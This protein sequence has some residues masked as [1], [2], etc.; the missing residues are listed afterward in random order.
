M[1]RPVRQL[2]RPVPLVL[3]V[4]W[5]LRPTSD[6]PLDARQER[7]LSAALAEALTTRGL[8]VRAEDVFWLDEKAS[9]LTA[10]LARPRAVLLGRRDASPN[11]VYLARTRLSPEGRL[12]DVT[13]LYPIT[14]TSAVDERQLAVDRLRA[15]W[16]V[17]TDAT[18]YS[19]HLA[20]FRGS[21]RPGG[22][23]WTALARLQQRI[24]NWQE[25]GQPEGVTRRSFRLDPVARSLVLGF[26]ETALLIQ[27]D[28]RRIEV[29]TDG[30]GPIRG[31]RFVR[32]TPDH[33]AR[34]GNLVTWAV[35][36]AR[37]LP[38]FGNDRMQ[39]IKAVTFWA[40]DKLESAYGSVT[41]DDGSER[42]AEELG[43]LLES[44][45]PAYPNPETGWPPRP[46]EPMLRPALKGEGQ[47]VVLERDPFVRGNPGA[48]SPFALSFIRTDRAR[49]YSQIYVTI[50]DP[51]QVQLHAM[52]GTKEPKS[53]T[54]ETGPG[55]VPREPRVMERLVGAF[56]G[57]FQATHGEYGMVAER[58]VYL[59]PLP[60]AATVAET[61]EGWNLFG[62]WPRDTAVPD[63]I[64]SLRQNMTPLLMDGRVNPYRREW[65]GGVPEGWTDDSRTVRS[66]L[67]LTEENFVAYFYGPSID[68]NHL[69]SGMQR[70]RCQYGIHLDMNAGHTGLEFYHV[71]KTGALPG[72]D[73]PLDAQWEATG[74]V[75]GMPGYS[76]LGRRMI[77]FMALMNFPRYIRRDARDFFYLTLRSLLP[78]EDVPTALASKE[79]G[80]GAW[81]VQGLPQHGWPHA[82]ATT[83]VR[84]DATRPETKINLIKLDPKQLRLVSSLRPE[85]RAV[86]AF[87]TPQPLPQGG[88]TLWWSK[89]GFTIQDE[90]PSVTAERVTHGFLPTRPPEPSVAAVGV[91]RDGLF[92]YAEVAT[93]PDPKHDGALLQELLGGLGVERLL[94]LDRPLGAA[95]AAERD[96]G[97]H[98]VSRTRNTLYLVRSEGPAAARFFTETPIVSPYEWFRYHSGPLKDPPPSRAR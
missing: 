95:I 28:D 3:F 71:A 21:E 58:V 41:G 74:P 36:R 11:D 31:E 97:G 46:M 26:S 63:T 94:L 19:V 20:D 22:D 44:P 8:S 12:L 55:L 81:Q 10:P 9:G 38:W 59:P 51:R 17:G 2:G 90:P 73:R 92:V 1:P 32:A 29:P 45:P 98:P 91:A 16:T 43:D 88:S 57:G 83:W 48:P 87:R 5:L 62:T 37:A 54:G 80:E 24:T 6:T 40:F 49:I 30:A 4:A 15:A 34:P 35:D 7:D 42:V 69:A 27:A 89:R 78:G 64:V 70:A 53:A 79:P 33:P 52:S 77:K 86:V 96:L 56:N 67:C 76:Y 65:W 75:P 85:D 66:G 60:Y 14:E 68:A 72:L 82:I 23:D 61:D 25:T 47:W 39:A 13:G 84:P 18:V 93:R 50:W